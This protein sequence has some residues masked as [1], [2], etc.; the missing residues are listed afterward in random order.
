MAPQFSTVIGHNS[1][2]KLKNLLN[3]AGFQVAPS[4]EEL[5]RL[6]IFGSLEEVAQAA[7]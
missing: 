6:E 1:E 3:S 4:R 2:Q 7:A 5:Y